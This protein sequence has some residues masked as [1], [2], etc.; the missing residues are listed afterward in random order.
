MVGKDILKNFKRIIGFALLII[1]LIINLLIPSSA[2]GK[3]KVYI[4]GKEFTGEIQVRNQTTYVDIV[5]FTLQM[6]PDAYANYDKQSKTVYVRSGQMYL[7]CE[8]NGNYIIANERYLYN[9]EPVYID[10]GIIYAPIMQ[11]Y[12]AFDA[13]IRWSDAAVGFY[14][15]RGSGAISPASS[16][17]REDAVY[18]LSR[19]ISA[20][21]RGESMLGKIAVGNVVL[22]R[23]RSKDFPNTIYG[24]IFDRKYGVQFTPA[25]NGTINEIPTAESIIAAKICL[26]YYS[27]NSEILYFVNP[28]ISPNSWASKNRSFYKK[29]GNHEFYY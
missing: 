1:C 4:D 13:K 22:N 19:I 24:V 2:E 5:E 21:A 28:D 27:L 14:I 18:W 16:Y 7:M 29:I 6:Y 8:A 11:L 15:T 3:V 26:E 23:V 10:N 20:E 17:Y 12:K 9:E 25:A